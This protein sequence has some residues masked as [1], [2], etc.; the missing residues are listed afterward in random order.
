MPTIVPARNVALHRLI[1]G[2]SGSTAPDGS[3]AG[4]VPTMLVAVMV[5]V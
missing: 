1:A 3:D 2:N 4:P 5:K